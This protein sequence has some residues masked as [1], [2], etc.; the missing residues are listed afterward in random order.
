MCV[1]YDDGKQK[2]YLVDALRPDGRAVHYKNLRLTPGADVWKSPQTGASYP[3]SWRIEIPEMKAT[4]N[5]RALL[6]DQEL[7]SGALHYWEGP[8]AVSGTL[9]GKRAGGN[10]FM[11]LVGYPA[12]R[13]AL[14][15]AGE[16][17]YSMIG[18]QL[19]RRWS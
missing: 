16:K 18:R 7:V 15:D 6:Q 12:R 3:M 8:L 11:E 1:E 5:V 4:F 14:T 17:L 13:G 10:G 19:G 9:N 2:D